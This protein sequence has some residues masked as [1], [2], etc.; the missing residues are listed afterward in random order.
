MADRRPCRVCGCW[1]DVD[2][3]AGRRHRVCPAES[4]QRTRNRRSCARWRGHHPDDV[5]AYRLRKRLPADPPPISEVVLLDP[6]A[7]LD[8]SVVRHAVG[9]EV[10]VVIELLAK[11]VLSLARHGVVP[12]MQ[13]GVTKSG[14]VPAGAARHETAD[15]RAPP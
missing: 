11:V 6:I 10:A 8:A 1:F 3:R 7:A 5:K 13:V 9:V 15:A 12:K 4:C 2:P 14:K